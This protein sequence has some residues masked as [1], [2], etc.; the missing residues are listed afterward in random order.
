MSTAPEDFVV[1]NADGL[2]DQRQR[3]C[4]FVDTLCRSPAFALVLA[5]TFFALGV[6][7]LAL[8][9]DNDDPAV[10]SC[11]SWH[12]AVIAFALAIYVVAVAF[13]RLGDDQDRVFDR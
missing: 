7:I 8:S 3:R 13:P 10:S 4:D 1:A 12:V 5:L 11:Q 6:A 2:E 9:I